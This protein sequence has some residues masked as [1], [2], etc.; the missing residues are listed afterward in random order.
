M[1]K[2]KQETSLRVVSMDEEC[3]Q[4][5]MMDNEVNGF[6]K[7]LSLSLL[8][9][10]PPSLSL[11]FSHRLPGKVENSHC[12]Y[13]SLTLPPLTVIDFSKKLHLTLSLWAVAAE[14]YIPL[15][16]EV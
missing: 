4:S 13:G 12:Y 8:L 9:S 2:E 5:L 10:L 15:M 7:S 1:V 3:A 16:V 6:T 14:D 11:T